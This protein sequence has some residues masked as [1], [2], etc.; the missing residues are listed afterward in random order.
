LKSAGS[1]YAIK[2]NAQRFRNF[3]TLMHKLAALELEVKE[4]AQLVEQGSCVACGSKTIQTTERYFPHSL[5][6]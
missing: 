6:H 4:S 5:T 3:K 2:E 1:A